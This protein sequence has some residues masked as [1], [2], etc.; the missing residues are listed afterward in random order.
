MTVSTMVSRFRKLFGTTC[1][2]LKRSFRRTRRQFSQPLAI[3][4]R[5]QHI[6]S[7]RNTI[8]SPD[9]RITG[10]NLRN[11]GVLAMQRYKHIFSAT[12]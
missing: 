11:Y 2:T 1:P 5:D 6:S 7:L 9:E 4:Q 12:P 3:P 10:Y 8:A